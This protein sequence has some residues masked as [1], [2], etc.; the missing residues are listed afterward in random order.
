MTPQQQAIIPLANP[1]FD[2]L[3][4]EEI[5]RAVKL[6]IEHNLSYNQI[7]K[8]VG[9]SKGAIFNHLSRLLPTE[10]TDDFKKHRADIFAHTQFRLLNSVTDEEIQKAPLGTK[11]LA[12]C[13]LYDKERLEAGKS[14]GNIAVLI[15][16]IEDT[17]G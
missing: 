16:M 9:R 6:R 5:Q 8:L 1:A 4:P 12:A 2:P 11:I 13:Q 17:Q 14:T 7:A 10:D 15:S 3:T